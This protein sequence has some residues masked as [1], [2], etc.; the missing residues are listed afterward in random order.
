[1]TPAR[2]G[3]R[4]VHLFERHGPAAR[5]VQEPLQLPHVDVACSYANFPIGAD[6]EVDGVAGRHFQVFPD[7][8]RQRELALA[9]KRRGGH[10]LIFYRLPYQ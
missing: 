5:L 7:L 3:D 1:M 6:D 4:F 8:L 10:V 2:Q 9:G